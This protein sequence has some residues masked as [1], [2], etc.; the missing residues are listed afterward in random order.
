MT[1]QNAVKN[2]LLKL[3][4]ERNITINKLSSLSAL[5]LSSIKNILYGKSCNPKLITIK[6]ICDG[7]NISLSEFFASEEFDNLDL[8]L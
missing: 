6:M 8:E 2:R 1:M 3:C 5:P 7:P 4:G